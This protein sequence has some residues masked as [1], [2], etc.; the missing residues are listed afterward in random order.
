MRVQAAGREWTAMAAMIKNRWDRG[1]SSSMFALVAASFLLPFVTVS[2]A[3]EKARRALVIQ[4]ED[5]ATLSGIELVTGSQPR[6]EYT[7]PTTGMQAKVRIPPEPFAIL[8]L[9]LAIAGAGTAFIRREQM[10][11]SMACAFAVAGAGSLFLL[12]LSPT[13]RG[14]GFTKT[15]IE[16]GYWLAM[17]GFALTAGLNAALIVRSRSS[18]PAPEASTESSVRSPPE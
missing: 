18:S 14:L 16:I 4:N 3:D 8:A 12:T 1:V 6:P 7:E 9:V 15:K 10:M 17:L 11:N 2:C 13:L 5:K